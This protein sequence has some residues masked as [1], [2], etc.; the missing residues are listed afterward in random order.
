MKLSDRPLH[1]EDT[2]LP[3]SGPLRGGCGL[4]ASFV[5][6]EPLSPS[7]R[8]IEEMVDALFDVNRYPES[9][10]ELKSLYRA[11]IWAEAAECPDRQ[12]LERDHRGVLEGPEARWPD[13]GARD[14]AQLRLLSHRRDRLRLRVDIGAPRLPHHQ[15]RPHGGSASTRKPGWSSSATR[16]T[17]RARSSM[18][19]PSSLPRLLAA[20]GARGRRR[21]LRGILGQPAIPQVDRATS[22]TIRCSCMRTFS[23]A[24]GLAGLRVGYGIGGGIA[25]LLH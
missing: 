25:R 19:T 1:P 6:R 12:R 15:P 7:P 5:E 18:T 2:L 11:E 8:V 4:G 10:S 17:R 3:E 22:T 21:G 23:K 13:E 9:E 16:T 24:Y 20:R 14:R